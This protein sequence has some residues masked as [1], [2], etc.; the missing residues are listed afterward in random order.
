MA[1][2][3]DTLLL[4]KDTVKIIGHDKYCIAG[5][6]PFTIGNSCSGEQP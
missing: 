1:G 3:I 4:S 6:K 5:W 2:G